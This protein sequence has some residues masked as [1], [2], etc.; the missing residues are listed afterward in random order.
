MQGAREGDRKEIKGEDDREHGEEERGT[1]QS[2]K[3]KA[4]LL[5][6]ETKQNNACLLLKGVITY[7]HMNDV[8][9][10]PHWLLLVTL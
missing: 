2:R 6:G 9:P 8:P 4:L 3:V 10:P 5:R 1:E 7:E